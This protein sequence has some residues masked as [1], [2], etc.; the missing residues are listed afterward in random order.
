MACILLFY[1]SHYTFQIA[2]FF[3]SSFTGPYLKAY[4]CFLETLARLHIFLINGIQV[5]L[6]FL[7]VSKKRRSATDKQKYEY[8]IGIK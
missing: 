7:I 1:R 2:Y 8:R 4:K 6:P 3:N 5:F